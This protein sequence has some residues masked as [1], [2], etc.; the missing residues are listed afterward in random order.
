MI[1]G[2]VLAVVGH[3]R[4]DLTE[5][6]GVEYLPQDIELGQE[7]RPHRLTG[8][9]PCSRGLLGDL[10]RLLGVDAQRFLHQDVLSGVQRG[11]CAGPVLGVR[12]A[13]V[14]DV[15]RRSASSDSYDP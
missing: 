8:E 3:H 11:E 5:H 4:A 2:E 12:G 7:S 6:P 13:H 9:Q 10:T 14:D 15:D 1:G